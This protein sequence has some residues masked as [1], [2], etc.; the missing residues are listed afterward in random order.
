ML[1]SGRPRPA[2]VASARERGPQSHSRLLM[3]CEL[4]ESTLNTAL[5]LLLS[6]RVIEVEPEAA[7]P[8]DDPTY[9]LSTRACALAGLGTILA[10]FGRRNGKNASVP[11]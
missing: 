9:E 4:S 1:T 5:G 8:A 10:L 11:A 7:V 2:F 6:E 3:D